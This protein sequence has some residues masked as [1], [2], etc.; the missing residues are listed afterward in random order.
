MAGD[1]YMKYFK[2]M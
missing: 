1:F 2:S